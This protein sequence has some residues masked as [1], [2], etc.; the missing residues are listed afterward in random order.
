[1]KGSCPGAS[2]FSVTA[3]HPETQREGRPGK[4]GGR[5]KVV[6]AGGTVEV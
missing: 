1:V 5:R 2:S 3:S 4:Q 6:A